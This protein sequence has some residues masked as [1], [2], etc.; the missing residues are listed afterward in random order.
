[1]PPSAKTVPLD[2]AKLD[3][4]ALVAVVRGGDRAAF[5]YV[6]QRFGQHLYRIARGVVNDDAEAED[7]VQEA[8]MRAYHQFGTFRGDAPLRTWLISILLN[9]ARSRL[10]KRHL[11]VGLEQI[12]PST[13]DPYWDGRSRPGSGG[14]DPASLAARAQIRRL[15]KRAIEK[16][17]DSYRMVFVLRE[18]EE[19][20]VEET[21]ARLTIKPQ[22]VKTRLHRARRLLRKSLGKTLGDV[23]ADTFPFLGARCAAL[24]TVLMAWLAAD[25]V[26]ESVDPARGLPVSRSVPDTANAGRSEPGGHTFTG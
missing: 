15:L 13:V 18:I 5:R 10:R 3:D 26:D 24:T 7:V 20:S 17:P 23:L 19:C 1:M 25:A 6:M 4:D 22:T 8:F 16:L 9:E 11:M 21:A 2:Y 14:A 12:T